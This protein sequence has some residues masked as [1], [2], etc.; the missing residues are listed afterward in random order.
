MSSYEWVKRKTVQAN[1]LIQ[2]S[3]FSPL[4]A[5]SSLLSARR[6]LSRSNGTMEQ[7]ETAGL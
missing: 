1:R 7:R 6:P 4:W 3:P 5:S 2:T